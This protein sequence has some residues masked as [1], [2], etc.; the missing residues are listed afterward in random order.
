MTRTTP[1]VMWAGRVYVARAGEW[2]DGGRPVGPVL[3]RL[4][5]HEMVTGKRVQGKTPI[6]V[7]G[8][9]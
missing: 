6:D 9:S 2:R 3:F 8:Q 7:L 4:D 1:G 5:S